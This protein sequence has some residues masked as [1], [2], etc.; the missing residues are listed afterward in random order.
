MRRKQKNK[1]AVFESLNKPLF[2]IRI[3]GKKDLSDHQKNLFNLLQLKNQ[4]EGKIVIDTEENIKIL[5]ALENM[6]IY[7]YVSNESIHKLI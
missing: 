4:H 5:K 3:H 6:I 1:N 2:V 7:G